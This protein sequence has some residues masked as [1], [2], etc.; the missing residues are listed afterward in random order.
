MALSRVFVVQDRQR[1]AMRGQDVL[2]MRMCLPAIL[3][4][5]VSSWSYGKTPGPG[6][7][8]DKPNNQN[9][10]PQKNPDTEQR[11]TDQAPFVIKVLPAPPSEPKSTP[12]ASQEKHKSSDWDWWWDKSPEILIALFTLGLWCAT[13]QL[14]RDAKKTSKRQLRAYISLVK[15]IQVNSTIRQELPAY[16][17]TVRNSGQTPAYSIKSWRGMGIQKHP[18]TSRLS[19]PQDPVDDAD[20]VL[21]NGTEMSNTDESRTPFSQA[22]MDDV[23]SGKAAIYYWGRY[24]Y[25][26]CFDQGHFTSFCLFQTEP[27]GGILRYSHIGNDA[28]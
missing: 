25:S 7:S 19:P 24:E 4:V 3:F 2:T 22:E 14:V 21:G 16:A 26:D 20:V 12:D 15:A 28:D 23:R 10:N 27:S 18:L 11:G 9:A 13:Y 1:Q 6:V 17:V 8:T 5:L